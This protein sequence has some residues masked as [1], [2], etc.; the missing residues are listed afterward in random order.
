MSADIGGY[1]WGN[2]RA[3]VG[4]YGWGNLLNFVLPRCTHAD[5]SSTRF[6]SCAFASTRFH[7]CTFVRSNW[8]WRRNV[9]LNFVLLVPRCAHGDESSTKFST[10]NCGYYSCSIRVPNL[11]GKYGRRAPRRYSLVCVVVR[12]VGFSFVYLRTWMG[13]LV[14]WVL[15]SWV[16]STD[17]MS[18]DVR[19]LNLVRPLRKKRVRKQIS[20]VLN[21]VLQ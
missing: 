12:L 3:D 10:R 18:V 9:L 1:G 17:E 8:S 6:H 2:L 11:V 15:S 16:P 13:K 5:E 19:V 4:G 20:A 14:G 21:L 7:S